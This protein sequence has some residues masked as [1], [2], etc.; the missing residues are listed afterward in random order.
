MTKKQAVLCPSDGKG[1]PT[2]PSAFPEL[3]QN[4]G[5]TSRFRN[6]NHADLNQTL[7]ASQAASGSQWTGDAGSTILTRNQTGSNGHLSQFPSIAQDVNKQPYPPIDP[8]A[9]ALLEEIAVEVQA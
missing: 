5:S 2:N 1:L 3:Y 6:Q 4:S 9:L 8:S 7:T